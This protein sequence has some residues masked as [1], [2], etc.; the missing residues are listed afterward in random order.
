MNEQ[1]RVKGG[2][3]EMLMIALPMLISMGCDAVMVFT[4]RLFLSRLSSDHMNA[5]MGGGIFLGT[6]TIFF[7]GL[8]AYSTA[9][10]A[11]YVGAGNKG[12]SSLITTQTM[13]FAV[14]GYPILLIVSPFVGSIFEKM[15]V[16]AT[17]LPLQI[18]YL[19]ILLMGSLFMLIRTSLSSFFSG[20]GATK[21]VMIAAFAS[22]LVNVGVNYCLIF[23]KLG[24]PQLG[25]RG[26][27][28]GTIIGTI[29]GVIVLAVAYF[30]KS[31]REEFEV[32]KSF[33]YSKEMMHKLLYYGFPQ[34]LEGFLSLIAFSSLTFIFHSEGDVVATA[35]TIIFN[36][37]YVSF[38][39]LIGIQIAVTSLVGKYMGAN[40]VK[41]ATNAALSGIKTGFFYSVIIFILFMSIPHL[42]VNLFRPSTLSSVFIDATPIAINMLKISTIY[43][44]ADAI[45]VSLVGALRGAGDTYWTM[46]T[47]VTVHWSTAIALFVV[48]K[49][50]KL[51]PEIGW[52]TVATF[53][54]LFCTIFIVRFRQGKWKTLKVID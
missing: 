27:A 52:A 7:T 42:L 43:V 53:F 44:L 26:A 54:L 3:K 14:L 8:I 49:V 28:I 37:D 4:D 1:S 30:K 6:L 51:S 38:M 2:I 48:I 23:G 19:R 36:W 22:M 25:I 20:I 50:L 24:F 32:M 10:V 46:L 33:V 41:S 45:L 31:I 47:S 9:L 15:G 35:A 21:Y 11:Q 29:A 34:G 5:S 13:I 17:Q 12:K 39:P 16:S 40:D 18:E